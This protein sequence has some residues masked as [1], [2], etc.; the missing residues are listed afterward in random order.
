MPHHPPTPRVTTTEALFAQ[1]C[2]A[3]PKEARDLSMLL[4][5]VERAALALSCNT[6]THLRAQGRAIASA[7]SLASL[8]EEGGQA[9][10]SLFDQAEAAA[11][12]WGAPVREGRRPVSLAG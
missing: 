10:L 3:T 9:G 12:T 2:R 11:D 6:R 7:C 1:I 5:M 4:T 8:V